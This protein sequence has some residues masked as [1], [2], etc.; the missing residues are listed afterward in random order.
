MNWKPSHMGPVVLLLW[1]PRPH[2][3]YFNEIGDVKTS[4][5]DFKQHPF[6]IS[7]FCAFR[8]LSTAE[9]SLHNLVKYEPR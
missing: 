2:I 8:N 1:H 6:I 7:Y 9:S 5:L 4:P 3:H